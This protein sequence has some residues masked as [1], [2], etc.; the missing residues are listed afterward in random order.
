MI[1]GDELF[2]IMMNTVL[3]LDMKKI[4]EYQL[5]DEMKADPDVQRMVLW[6]TRKKPNKSGQTENKRVVNLFK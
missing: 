6:A 5:Y 3:Y 4:I 1:S 2:D